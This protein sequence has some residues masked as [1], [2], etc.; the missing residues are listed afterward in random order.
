MKKKRGT[1]EISND[2]DFQIALE[3]ATK[4]DYSGPGSGGDNKRRKV[5]GK[6]M[7]KNAKYGQGGKKSGS[8]KNDAASSADISGFSSKKMKG[9]SSRPGKSKRSRR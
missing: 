7:A 4:D 3:E 9:K 5:N 6:R 8:R 2:D 1:N